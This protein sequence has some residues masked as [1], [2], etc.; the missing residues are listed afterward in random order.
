MQVF[1]D[2]KGRDWQ[3]EITIGSAR[4]ATGMIDLLDGS[5]EQLVEELLTRP[6]LRMDLLWHFC[7]NKE[8]VSRD[9]FDEGLA[10][11][12]LVESD[13]ALWDEIVF[14]IQ[15]LRPETQGVLPKLTQR[16]KDMYQEQMKM[17]IEFSQSEEFVKAA[18]QKIQQV[19][20]EALHTLSGKQPGSSE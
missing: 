8:D 12:A 18:E 16:V 5:P 3:I 13:R 6:L 2:A 1:K 14:F 20:D 10:G 19:K 11:K 15:S 4:K 9:E 17:I 7:V